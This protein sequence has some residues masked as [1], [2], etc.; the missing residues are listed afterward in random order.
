MRLKTQIDLLNSRI[1]DEMHRRKL[2]EDR[3]KAIKEYNEKI[4]LHST[5]VESNN[6]SLNKNVTELTTKLNKL[7]KE[8]RDQAN[9]ALTH[10]LTHSPTHS[11]AHSLRPHPRNSR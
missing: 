2:S 9:E 10:P 5:E 6:N 7:K 4:K 1:D 11:L 8:L 3:M